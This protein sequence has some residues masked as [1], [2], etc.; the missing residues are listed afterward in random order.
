MDKTVIRNLIKEKALVYKDESDNFLFIEGGGNWIFD[1]RK[2]FLEGQNLELMSAFFWDMYENE[3]PFQVWGL[4]LSA[5]PFVS[6]IILE[7][8]KRGKDVNGFIVRKDRKETGLWKKIEGTLN[9][10]K[11]IIVDDLLNSAQSFSLVHKTLEH[12]WR[13]IYKLF[14][15]IHF[16]NERGRKYI[17]DHSIS[18]DYA[19]TLSEFDVDIFQNSLKMPKTYNQAPMIFPK[20]QRL[21]FLDN[22][23]AFV[24]APKSNPLRY[25]NR[26]YLWGEGG[27]FVC[28]CSDTG[29]LHWE[30]QV[31]CTRGHKNILSS[32]ILVDNLVI[33]WSYDG[34]LYALD[35]EIGTLVWKFQDADWI[36]S[37]PCYS[38]KEKLVFVWLEHAGPRNRGSLVA[39]NIQTGE[40]RWECMFDNFIHSSPVYSDIYDV[41]ICGSNDWVI[42][43]F[44]GSTWEILWSYTCEQDVKWAAAFSPKQESVYIGWFDSIL[45]SFDTQTGEN[46]F[47][48]HTENSIYARPLTHKNDIYFASLDKCFYHL[49]SKGE[50]VW[51]VDTYGK[52]FC[53]PIM[54]EDR[55][56]AFGS[57]DGYIYL[58]DSKEK[59]T[60]FVIEHGERITTKLIYDSTFGAL[61]AYDYMNQLYKYNIWS[62]VK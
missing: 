53:E 25:N 12:E 52:I 13:D 8:K 34:N 14:T 58:Y 41:V 49:N 61:Y 16:W 9:D 20:Y 43:A 24:P 29:D 46:I 40:K 35:A 23:N 1:F 4:E 37:S 7:G 44:R 5:V 62:F 28:I 15:F 47:S 50:C 59:K 33:F 6:G 32:P 3:F 55:Y 51:K 39:L 21:L 57:N 60:R 36:G 10:E 48:F 45:Y 42:A 18:Y 11:I 17:A 19:F 27:K 56:I 30:F 22:A 31:P 2:L 26:I 38:E 54:I